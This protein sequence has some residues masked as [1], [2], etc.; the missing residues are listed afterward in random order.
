MEQAIEATTTVSAAYARAREI[1][2]DDPGAVL[3]ESSSPEDR[4]ARRFLAQLAVDL[5]GGASVHQEV[6]I[7]LG[8]PGPDTGLTL[9]LSWRATGH[10]ALYPTFEG[11]LAASPHRVGTRLTLT[12]RYRLPLGAFGRFGD[13]VAGRKLA[14]A[15]LAAFLDGVARRLDDEIDQRIGSVPKHRAPYSIAVTDRMESENYIG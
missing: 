12:G 13:A 2:I 5:G 6:E 15:S 14:R 11:A 7:R 1:L 8:A 3:S 4:R 10:A 9:P